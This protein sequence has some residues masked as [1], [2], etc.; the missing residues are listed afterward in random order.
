MSGL[1]PLAWGLVALLLGGC[2]GEADPLADLRRVVEQ[3]PPEEEVELKPLPEPVEPKQ[4][5]FT[6]LERSPF[7]GLAAATAGEKGEEEGE[8]GGGPRP[9][10]DR[11][12]EP[13]EEYA[14]GSLKLVGTLKL[15]DG[16]W[17]AFVEAP[18][19]LVHT[20]GVGSHMGQRHGRVE[21]ISSDGLELRELVP[22]GE[23]RW[24]AQHRTVS[25][26]SKATGE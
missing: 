9:D 20:V 8:E 24:E 18:D 16:Q 4:V 22:R 6:P 10:P 17:R 25:I 2:G 7:A 5:S 14:I 15:P 23:G 26:Q 12:E 3:P 19:G 11:P 21:A 13:L 1:R